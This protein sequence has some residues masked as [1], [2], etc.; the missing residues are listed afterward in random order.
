MNTRLNRLNRLNRIKY[1]GFTNR[2]KKYYRRM[3]VKE[4]ILSRCFNNYTNYLISCIVDKIRYLLDKYVN[5]QWEILKECIP[6][7][8]DYDSSEELKQDETKIKS[9]QIVVDSDEDMD[10]Q[11]TADDEEYVQMK[12]KYNNPKKSKDETQK[13]ELE[14]KSVQVI[15]KK[16]SKAEIILTQTKIKSKN[17]D[18]EEC[19]QMK[20]E[21]DDLEDEHDKREFNSELIEPRGKKIKYN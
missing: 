8:V 21:Y 2:M 5:K 10:K 6:M 13:K 18:E 11:K 12:L 14:T 17:C 16:G 4:N 20:V 15:E 3:F 7:E 19:E 9:V 1:Y